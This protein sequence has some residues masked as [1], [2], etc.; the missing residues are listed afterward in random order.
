MRTNR[1]HFQPRYL[2]L[3]EKLRDELRQ[4]YHVG[5]RFP[6]QNEL[7]A[8]YDSSYCTVMHALQN[9]VEEGYLRREQGRGTFVE[10]LPGGVDLPLA[11]AHGMIGVLMPGHENDSDQFMLDQS[12][13][14]I[15]AANSMDIVVQFLPN[16]LL[17]GAMPVRAIQDC[18]VS[19]LIC[20]NPLSL[21]EALRR[22]LAA[23]FHTVFAEK[24]TGGQ[25]PYSWC[26][27]D[28]AAGIR[29]GMGALLKAGHTRIALLNGRSDKYPIY[30][31]R[32][33]AYEEALSAAGLPVDPELVVEAELNV[34]SGRQAMAKLYLR[35]PDAV[36]FATASCGLGALNYLNAERVRIPNEM[37]VVGF[38]DQ[39]YYSSAFQCLTTV[40]QPV[41]EFAASLVNQLQRLMSG[42]DAPGTGKVLLPV[43]VKGLSI[44]NRK[45]Q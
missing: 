30:Q 31:L 26:D 17:T 13:Y 35:H 9:L 8:R 37:S 43:L 2:M 29:L 16:R 34:L 1:N 15:K 14:I 6:S 22:Q 5:S 21:S 12:K 39:L 23:N 45:K 18:G 10:A 41:R 19:G 38:D 4:N 11:K 44:S 7:L 28:S 42:E 33:K 27:M 32:R 40:E 25:P 20:C 24:L 3:T 36:L